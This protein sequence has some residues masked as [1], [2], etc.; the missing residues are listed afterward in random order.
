MSVYDFDLFIIGSGSGGGRA[1]RVAAQYGQ[2]VA[3]AENR[4]IGGTCV[5]LGCVPKKLMTYAAGYAAHIADAA[6]FGWSIGP[7]SHD[8]KK[9]IAAQDKEIEFLNTM[10]REGIESDEQPIFDGTAKITGPNEVQVIGKTISAQ[11]ILIATG[12]K[13]FIPDIPGAKEYGIT[14]DD[15]FSLPERPQK[16]VIHGA[17]YIALEFAGIF[18]QLGSEVHV[19]FR[20]ET[21]LNPGFDTEVRTFLQKQMEAKG[22]KLH[23]GTNVARVE[24]TECGVSV[25][26]TDNTAIQSGA[27]LFATGRV[28]NIEPLGLDEVGVELA[29][30]GAIKVDRDQQTSIPSIYAIGD[31]TGHIALTPVAI[32]EGHALADRLYG[33]LRRYIS[34][35][36][37]PHAIFSNPPVGQVGLT[38]EQALEKHP[39]KIDV[40]RDDF[41]GMKNALAGRDERTLVKLIVHSETGRVLG[42]HMVGQDAPEITQGFATAIVAGATKADFDRTIAIH[43]TIAEEFVLLRHKLR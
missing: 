25:T 16:I 42:L 26:L 29:P 22:I 34:Y 21:I 31:V 14:S 20:R 32:A 2:R 11:R 15:V 36:N 5:N 13:P 10:I 18:N 37:V 6:G 40:Y 9:F 27:I 39:G 7:S 23:P 17:G 1:G 4:H 12:A 41:L 30:G 35:E 33:G 8:W 38:E 24:K 3:Y 43:P 19:V 28:P